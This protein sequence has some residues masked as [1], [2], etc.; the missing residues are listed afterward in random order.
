MPTSLLLLLGFLLTAPMT[1]GQER[2]TPPSTDVRGE[3]MYQVLQAGDIP[4][5]FDPIW[6]TLDEAAA[7]YHDREPLIVATVDASVV[8]ASTWHLDRHEIVNTYLNG[9][10]IT[11]TW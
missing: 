4:A 8:G 1:S 3:P 6:L 9:K 11:I 5:I 10:A 7:L 2:S